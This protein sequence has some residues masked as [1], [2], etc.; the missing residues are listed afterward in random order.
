MKKVRASLNESRSLDWYVTQVVAWMEANNLDEQEIDL[1]MNDPDVA[2]MVL[3][4]HDEGVYPHIA[5]LD[6]MQLADES[7]LVPNESPKPKPGGVREELNEDDHQDPDDD[8]KLARR[9]LKI[10]KDKAESL[11][12]LV[13]PGTPLDAWCQSKLTIAE[14]YLTA[15][16][17]YMEYED[18]GEEGVAQ[19]ITDV[20]PADVAPEA[21]VPLV[22]PE[23][24]VA[25]DIAIDPE[26]EMG[27]E[28]MPDGGADTA[29]MGP[30]APTPEDITASFADYEEG[31]GDTVPES[32][33]EQ[34]EDH[35]AGEWQRQE[36]DRRYNQEPP[37]YDPEDY[38]EPYD[39]DMDECF[40]SE[41]LRSYMK[42]NL[43]EK[44]FSEGSRK[45]LA[46]KGVAMK[47]GSYPIQSKKDLK[48]AI[49]A[50]GRAKNKAA[51]KRHILKRARSLGASDLIPDNWK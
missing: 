15:I 26:D 37:D 20:P 31:M 25:I 21:P 9:Q 49:K 3:K 19:I 4:K 33:E 8:S 51:T 14:N 48:N 39:A 34:G 16:S 38:E 36:A 42:G 5:A 17:N 28:D 29:M 12:Q 2:D 32:L 27:M 22:S 1:I 44:E 11:L 47:D 24:D 35:P 50:Y 23:Q 18:E 40:I 41:S 30:D 10:I 46:K 6:L 13:Q 43:N 7:G 45:N